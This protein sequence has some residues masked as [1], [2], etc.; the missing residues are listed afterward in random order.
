MNTK[1]FSQY[2]FLYRFLKTATVNVAS[3]IMIPLAGGISVAFMGHLPNINYLAGVA[4]GS[5]LFSLLYESCSFI[6][7]GTTAITSQAVGSDDREA[8]IL[9]GLQNAL[10]ALGL[11]MLLLLLQYPLGKLGFML[12]SATADVKLAGIAYFNSRILGAP[13][14]LV[15]LVLM[16]WFLGREKNR[17]VWLLVIIGNAANVVLDYVYIILWNWSSM[18]AGLSQAISQYLTLFVGLVMISREFSLKEIADLTGKILNVSALKAIFAINGNLSVRSTVIASIFV[19]FTTFSATL[20]TDVL[21][22]N[23]LLL[24]IVALS[25]YMCDGVEY[26]TVTLTGNFQ[27]QEARHKFVPLL[28]IALATNLAIALVVG[29][30][31]IFFPDPIFH[32]FT[33]HSEL[34]EAIKVYI[35][36]IIL[37]VVGSGFAYILDGY[38]AG[39]GEGTAIRNTYLISGSLGFISLALS[40]FYFHSNHFLWLSLSMFMLSCTLILGVQ[41]PMTLQLNEEKEAVTINEI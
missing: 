4:L 29:L 21:A 1:I 3:N 25:M 32:I 26:A 23:V 18:G 27:G 15:N 41:I 40:T 20:G 14:A 19:L 9:A 30:A 2:D 12:L 22:E 13:A 31:A 35:P 5:I 16:G 24:Q 8:T 37:V 34:I 33:N 7:S 36:W 11:G 10:I 6:K 28:Q 17:Q 38:F 39:L